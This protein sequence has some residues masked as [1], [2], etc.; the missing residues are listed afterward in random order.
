MR[1]VR[2]IKVRANFTRTLR[3]KDLE[4]LGIPHLN[5]PLSFH[6]GNQFTLVMSNKM[7]ESLV[8]KLPKE[9]M[10]FDPEGDD[11]TPE[12]LEPLTSLM[13]SINSKPE[14]SSDDSLG[15]PDDDDESSTGDD[16]PDE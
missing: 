1:R 5:K 16:G 9:F 10:M 6:S 14:E 13:P 3:V 8:A 4:M 7:A 12:V 11:E 2:Y 15:D